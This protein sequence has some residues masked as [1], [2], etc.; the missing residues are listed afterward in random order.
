MS[1]HNIIRVKNKILSFVKDPL[2]LVFIGIATIMWYLNHLNATYMNDVN[3]P[4]TVRGVE[5]VNNG[6]SAGSVNVVC[7]VRGNGYTLLLMSLIPQYAAVEVSAS[8][9]T[10]TKDP[11]DSSFYNIN[12]RSLERAISAQIKNVELIGVLNNEIRIKGDRYAEKIVPV[13]LDIVHDRSGQYMKTMPSVIEP[14]NI[15]IKGPIRIIND[16]KN[17]ETEPINVTSEQKE[18]VGLV[19]LEIP[20]GVES[21]VSEVKYNL[22]YDIFTERR[23]TQKVEVRGEKGKFIVLPSSVS[24]KFNVPVSK[25]KEDRKLTTYID[26][27][28]DPKT[29]SGYIGENRYLVKI[30]GDLSGSEDIEI[31]PRYVTVIKEESGK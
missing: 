22:E 8:D 16:I 4:V 27:G 25:M 14:A 2:L 1:K 18:Y 21:S 12:I 31:T 3:I 6:N 24:V 9:L 23:V 5:G 13:V 20:E 19:Q 30:D 11:V 28:N 15:L 29:N 26:Y 7:Q 10:V 17:I